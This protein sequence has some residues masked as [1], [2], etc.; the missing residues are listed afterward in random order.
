[1]QLKDFDYYLPK[2]LIAPYPAKPRDHSRLLILNRKTGKIEHRYFYDLP[3]Y[4]KPG[5]VLVF[6]NTKVRHA[7][8]IGQK[9]TT[10]GKVEIFLLKKEKTLAAGEIWQCLLGGARRKEGLRVDFKKKLKAR[11]LKRNADNTWLVLFNKKG[12]VLEKIIEQIGEMPLPP[13]IKRGAERVDEKSYQ[14]IYANPKK[15]GSVAAPT[16]G[17]HFTPGLLKKLKA[18]GVQFENIT[19]HVGLGTFA[20]V[21]TENIKE[22]KMH[23]EWVEIEAEALKRIIKAKRDNKRI[24]AV[25]TTSTRTLEAV[26]PKGKAAKNKFKHQDFSGWVDIFIYPGYKFKAVDAMVTNFHLPKSTLV[27]LVSAFAGQP[28]RTN[29][30]KSIFQAYGEAIKRNYRFFSYGDAMLII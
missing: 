23:A 8:L 14:T 5:D 6:N 26:L 30:R 12:K 27:M 21:K 19:L 2:E 28:S 7:R 9:E 11:V 13:Y 15:L 24:I 25:G 4:L 20:P 16:A 3:Q 29:G 22:H 18:R 1:M 17:L 10:G